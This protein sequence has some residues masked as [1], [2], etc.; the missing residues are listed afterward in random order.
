MKKRTG[1]WIDKKE[2]YIVSLTVDNVETKHFESSIDTFHPKGGSRGKKAYGP[3][4]TVKEKSYLERE[5]QQ[6]QVFLQRIYTE[7]S[8]SSQMYIF[9]PAQM[10]DQLEKF[11]LNLPEPRP[12]VLKLEAADSMT[13]KQITAKVK[14][15]Y[16]HETDL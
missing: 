4:I 9:G 3:V 13:K 2:A 6:T 5:K 14:D 10:K 16:R 8:D 11:I 7:I 1:I 12:Q 15:F